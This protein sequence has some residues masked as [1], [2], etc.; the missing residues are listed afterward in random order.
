MH[1]NDNLREYDYMG[2]MLTLNE[3]YKK[4]FSIEL[5]DDIDKYVLV[6]LTDYMPNN[7]TIYTPFS[8]NKSMYENKLLIKSYRDTVHFAVNGRVGSH[9]F[10]DW[11]NKKYA[12]IIP[13]KS[14][15][16]KNGDR[17]LNSRVE[18]MYIDGSAILPHDAFILCPESE[19]EA[20]NTSNNLNVVGVPGDN[21]VPYV[22]DVLKHLGY[23][24]YDI[25]AWGYIDDTDRNIQNSFS[26]QLSNY[27]GRSIPQTV[28]SSSY[29]SS[30]EMLL[31]S[32]N[33]VKQQLEFMV[34]NDLLDLDEIKNVKNSIS[35]YGVQYERS[36]SDKNLD[37]ENIKKL[38]NA[39]LDE[40][41]K[42]GDERV[43][44]I[45]FL[46]TEYGYGSLADF[47]TGLERLYPSMMMQGN[48]I[49]DYYASIG[50]SE[51]Q[52]NS[53]ENNKD[54]LW[55]RVIES[56]KIDSFIGKTMEN[57]YNGD[58]LL[59][60]FER[61]EDVYS[62]V[63]KDNLFNDKNA[64]M[65]MQ[66]VVSHLQTDYLLMK[67]YRN[68]IETNKA[69]FNFDEYSKSLDEVL[70]KYGVNHTIL[71]AN[72]LRNLIAS[73]LSREQFI[74]NYHV[75]IEDFLRENQSVKQLDEMVKNSIGLDVMISPELVFF[76]VNDEQ[77]N[78]LSK[79]ENFIL[80][81]NAEVDSKEKC[82]VLP[83]KNLTFGNLKQ[84][85]DYIKSINASLYLDDEKNIKSR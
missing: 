7:N 19:L 10:G 48:K 68:E 65:I 49:N 73:N 6:H 3:F 66:Y 21:V 9:G 67:K 5:T 63:V 52:L 23:H 64:M 80:S 26:L 56:Y 72:K 61:L 15:L 71:D 76:D 59:A 77:I 33:N 4:K 17:V 85:H 2:D 75:K 47:S 32:L 34:H 11:S 51:L 42:N 54:S 30:E 78:Y 20:L 25:G 40:K 16:K 81:F 29:K 22:D 35:F 31:F 46:L 8:T 38:R 37:Q 83:I 1:N 53:F 13:L 69:G 14:F 55:K 27:L 74:K 41:F 82:V 50:L 39:Y 45:Y 58:I 28:H 24:T 57:I 44:K 12:I 70:R 36:L 62:K 43:K 84:I 60:N 79:D 18:D